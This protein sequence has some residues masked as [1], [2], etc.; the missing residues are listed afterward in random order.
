VI[1]RAVSD[2]VDESGDVVVGNLAAWQQAADQMM[3][4]LLELAADALPDLVR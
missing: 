4:A 2:V 1:L 3:A